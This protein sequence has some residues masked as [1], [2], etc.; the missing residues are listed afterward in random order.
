MKRIGL[1][2]SYAGRPVAVT[3]LKYQP[4]S[5]VSECGVY[6]PF[7][8]P[9]PDN[10]Q[11]TGQASSTCGKCAPDVTSCWAHQPSRINPEIMG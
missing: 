7:R 9:T 1:P 8:P 11:P 3:V 4:R 6:G 10:P 5:E 2:P